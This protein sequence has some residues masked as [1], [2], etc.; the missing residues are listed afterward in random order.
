M[1]GRWWAPVRGGG[2]SRRWAVGMHLAASQA[3]CK[4]MNRSPP[5]LLTDEPLQLLGVVLR[6]EPCTTTQAGRQAGRDR[7]RK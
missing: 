1:V 2:P 4:P 6:L 5:C 7:Q 3:V